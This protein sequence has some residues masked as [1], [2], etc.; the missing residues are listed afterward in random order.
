MK[1]DS[2]EQV[3]VRRRIASSIALEQ[4]VEI[5]HPRQGAIEIQHDKPGKQ[6]AWHKH[7]SDETII[8]I[9]GD[10]HFVWEAGE[11][12]CMA[13]DVI[14]LPLGMLH[15]STAGADGATYIIS[16]RTVEI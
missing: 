7:D 11:A 2:N 1:Q 12:T 9:D 15:G 16:F 6:H 8:I 3:K 13:G 10:M 5:C 4:L 14:N